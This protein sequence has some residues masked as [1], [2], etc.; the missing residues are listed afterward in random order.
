MRFSPHFANT[1]CDNAKQPH[2][3]EPSNKKSLAEFHHFV[4]RAT[5]ASRFL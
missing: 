3:P 2:T 1:K 4:I 5:Y